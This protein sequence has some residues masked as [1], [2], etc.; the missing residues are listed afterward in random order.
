M[1]EN[2]SLQKKS[3]EEWLVRVVREKLNLNWVVLLWQFGTSTITWEQTT[4]LLLT[5]NNRKFP[6]RTGSHEVIEERIDSIE[7]STNS[8]IRSI[9]AYTHK[10]GIQKDFIKWHQHRA[11]YVWKELRWKWTANFLYNNL[12]KLCWREQTECTYVPSLLYFHLKH[13]FEVQKIHI[14]REWLEFSPDYPLTEKQRILIHNLILWSLENWD[15]S[16]PF[17]VE[18]SY[19][20][21]KLENKGINEDILNEYDGI[22]NIIQ[23]TQSISD[24]WYRQFLY[25]SPEVQFLIEGELW[26]SANLSQ[27]KLKRFAWNISRRV[28]WF[29]S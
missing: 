20:W 15:L 11:L 28:G 6:K 10:W 22:K 18:L 21:A 5:S 16:L 23:N 24:T 3:S 25:H 9:L 2:S 4:S 8:K 7:E 14:I 29:L 27:D 26:L 17:F 12:N 19:T 1:R 13:W